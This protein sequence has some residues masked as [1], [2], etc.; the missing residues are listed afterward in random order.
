[1]ETKIFKLRRTIA[2]ICLFVALGGAILAWHYFPGKGAADELPFTEPLQKA[3]DIRLDWSGKNADIALIVLAAL[4]GLALA[5]KEETR[6]LGAD[7]PEW[8]MFVSANLLMG[9]AFY[10]HQ[11]LTHNVATALADAVRIVPPVNDEPAKVPDIFGP[12]FQWSYTLQLWL[13]ALGLIAGMLTFFS[14]HYLKQDESHPCPHP[15][16][17]CP[18]SRFGP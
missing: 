15:V 11:K 14:V 9:G 10:V 16:F 6:I 3:I 2:I 17:A 8:L 1:M 13:I 5:G 12:L 7:W 4:W 18:L